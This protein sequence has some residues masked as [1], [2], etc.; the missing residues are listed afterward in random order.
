MSSFD[1]S[2]CRNLESHW[3]LMNILRLM[4]IAKS[5]VLRKVV[6]CRL[7]AVV[8][9]WI[10]AGTVVVG[11]AGNLTAGARAGD[12]ASITVLA[13]QFGRQIRQVR[14]L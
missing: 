13:Q 2:V 10:N 5:E 4:H 14:G 9:A 1:R 7:G 3:G 8:A 6:A 12:L 11:V